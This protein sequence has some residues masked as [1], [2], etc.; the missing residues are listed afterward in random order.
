MFL[1]VASK[2]KQ[3]PPVYLI[4]VSITVTVIFLFHSDCLCRKEI[5]SIFPCVQLVHRKRCVFSSE[6]LTFVYFIMQFVRHKAAQKL[7]AS[8]GGSRECLG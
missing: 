8:F 7:S 6:M 5:P 2:S 4:T 3:C 1:S